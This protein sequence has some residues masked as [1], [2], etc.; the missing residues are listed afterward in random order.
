MGSAA[1]EPKER[2]K[3]APLTEEQKAA[4]AAKAKA[5]REA[6]KAKAAAEPK[7]AEAVA[8]SAPSAADE[9][10]KPAEKVAEPKK[11]FAKKTVAAKPA[12]TLEQLQD[13]NEQDIDGETY[14]VNVRGDVVDGEGA[15]VGNWNG[16][17]L[18]KG[19]PPADRE[20]VIG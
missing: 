4:K 3:P 11:A 18:T 19:A 9:A 5:T 6:N 15:Y 17:V 8:E 20:K 10:P 1:K 13:F 12:Y 7:E 2:K 16:T 14:G